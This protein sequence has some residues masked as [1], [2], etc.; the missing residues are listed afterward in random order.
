MTSL[1]KLQ[2]LKVTFHQ[3][4]QSFNVIDGI[5]L[6]IN[7][8]KTL[9]LVGESGCGKSM[10]ALSI[11][12]LLP[13]PAGKITGGDIQFNNQSLLALPE[14]FMRKVRGKKIAMI[15]QEPMTAL[16]PVLT[17][18]QQIRETLLEHNT[19]SKTDCNK[20][21]IS[22][23]NQ[24]GIPDPKNRQHAYPHQLSGGLKQR[25]VI[26]IA[27]ACEPDLL[28]AD[29]PTTALDVTIQSQIL[30]TL[31]ELQ[32]KLGLSILLITHD[33][34]IVAQMADDI[35]VMY[36]GQIVEQATKKEF[37][38]YQYHPYSK[39]LFSALPDANKKGQLLEV[40]PGQ[41]PSLQSTFK[42]CRFAMRCEFC[43]DQCL[44][45]QPEINN[46]VLCHRSTEHLSLASSITENNHQNNQSDTILQVNNLSVHFPVGR[47]FLKK[48]AETI[49]AVNGVNLEIKRGKT[50]ALVGESG[51]GKSTVGKAIL[52]LIRP[53]SGE[54]IFQGQALHKLSAHRLKRIRSSLQIIFQDPFSSL[55][56]RMTINEILNEGMIA[57]NIGKDRQDRL[58]KINQLL[59]KTGLPH[60][61]LNRFPHE[62]SGGQ[63]QRI[64]IARA[65]S[66]EPKLIVCDEP[67]SAL[68][69]SVQ[70]QIL[71][72][73]QALQHES[74]L[75]FLFI[76]HN[77]A[78]VSYIADE[79]AVMYAGQ[80]IE[81]GRVENI[82]AS[83]KHPYTQLLLSSVPNINKMSIIEGELQGDLPSPVN[84]P[85]GCH[86]H[87]RCPQAETK[88]KL[89]TPSKTLTDNGYIYCHRQK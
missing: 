20:R 54:I 45:K 86:F 30:Q 70:A 11:M 29:E 68:D 65:L 52:Q 8:G 7:R 32:E 55:N 19:L 21:I 58:N 75:A 46:G 72:L 23:L 42:G 22:L 18:K 9:A 16:N 47:N 24:V 67:T 77:M 79:V 81:Y 60:D 76:T 41:V 33:L 74:G 28:I 31:K 38:Q 17:V 40:I 71:N 80:I 59:T 50:I 15:F 87:P 63:R 27:L 12:R 78:V 73:L 26:A 57:Q 51:C 56:P 13:W 89:E 64:G 85:T 62:F 5:S 25:V 88:C 6:R 37:F 69:V 4:K 84:L 10:T 43:L 48:N 34:G 83:P 61:I 82:L 36:A 35:A 44:T 53:T 3:K 1:L 14:K 66:V 49:H 2:N 39:H